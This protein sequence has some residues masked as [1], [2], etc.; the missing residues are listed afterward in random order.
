M[1][2]DD[3]RQKR[4]NGAKD[5]KGILE[6]QSKIGFRDLYTGDESWIFTI[7]NLK[8]M[9]MSLEEPVQTKPQTTIQ[10]EKHML[11]VFG[12]LMVLK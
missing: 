4:V 3:L 1:L 12:V 7:N 9:W 2:T 8:D 6:S 11:T 5:L 10:A